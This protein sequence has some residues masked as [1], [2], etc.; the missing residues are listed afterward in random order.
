MRWEATRPSEKEIKKR[1][2]ELLILQEC[3][4]VPKKSDVVTFDV[5]DIMLI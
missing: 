1:K 3:N 5:A 4:F 2:I